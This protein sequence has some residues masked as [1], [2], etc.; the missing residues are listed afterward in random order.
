VRRAADLTEEAG[1]ARY[2]LEH[3]APTQRNI[4]RE[5]LSP[6]FVRYDDSRGVSEARFVTEDGEV[7]LLF[8]YTG[9]EMLVQHL[10]ITADTGKTT[11]S[12]CSGG[13]PT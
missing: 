3:Y 2:E 12:S 9:D 8:L 1:S 5:S 13:P 11:R 4:P 10:G 7:N 6:R